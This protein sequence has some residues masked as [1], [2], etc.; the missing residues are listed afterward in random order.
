ME[1]LN[2]VMPPFARIQWVSKEVKLKYEP[3]LEKA[4]NVY[5][6]LEELS[7]QHGLR[8]CTTS[9]VDPNRMD[10]RQQEYIKKG[11]Y[12]LPQEKV[13][14]YTGFSN[15]HPPVEEGKPWHYYGVVADTVENALKFAEATDRLDH[16]TL[17]QLLDFP[18]CCVEFFNENWVKKGIHDPVW[19]QALNANEKNIRI[20]EDNLI[21]LKDI[22]WQA[23][24]LLKYLSVGVIFHVCDSLTCEKTLKRSMD[25]INL[26]KELKIDGLKEL[27]MFL[28]MPMEW[29]ALKGIAYIRTPLFKLAI[30]SVT[31]TE[32][33]KVQ[34]EGTYF[35][36][37]VPRGN[38][39]PWSEQFVTV[40]R[41]GNKLEN[42]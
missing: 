41:N 33:F 1:L 2:F 26:A 7:V 22:P 9:H 29:D 13:G 31:C 15:Y 3:M 18:E 30:N 24:P 6:Q 21:R 8:H 40:A 39:Y 35:P 25:W 42:E 5:L 12:F 17:G 27:E 20:K 38:E 10:I 36:D 23:N 4:K 14:H 16:T 28:R 19:Q 37:D 32:R 34:L 11:M